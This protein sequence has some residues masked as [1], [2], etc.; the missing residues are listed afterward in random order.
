M[1]DSDACA[2]SMPSVALS[3]P[4]PQA[5]K[6][7]NRSRPVSPLRQ[8]FLIVSFWKTEVLMYFGASDGKG[9]LVCAGRWLAPPQGRAMKPG[10]P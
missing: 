10:L 2:D 5:D 4:P 8:L 7:A 6:V 1:L 3:P 9:L